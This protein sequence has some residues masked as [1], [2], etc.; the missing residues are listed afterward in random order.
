MNPIEIINLYKS[1]G[2]VTAVKGVSLEVKPGEIFG[3]IGPDGAGKTTI[4][5]TIVSLLLPDK[6]EIYFQG[7]EVSKNMAFVR[8]NIGY[9]P[10]R[11]S[12]YPDLTVEENL[13]FFADLFTVPR[14]EQQRI[15]MKLYEFS[16]LGPFKNRRAG[17]LSGGMK[18]KLA[19]S[20]MLVHEPA[21]IILDEP[22]F[23]VDPVSRSE[24][25]DI[26]KELARNGTSILVT[27]A[28]MDEAGL[29][30]RIGLIFEGKILAINTPAQLLESYGKQIYVVE[31]DQAHNVFEKLR[32]GGSCGSCN[33]FGDGVHIT[34]DHDITAESIRQEL[35]KL[36]LNYRSVRPIDPTLEDLFLELMIQK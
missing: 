6:G 26:L 17:A 29:C 31:T 15:K 21:V 13:N 8:S 25:W 24:F 5:R 32:A 4:I 11:F 10:Q 12:L 14:S 2:V 30:N 34:G 20:C 27:T 7:K 16:R 22:T 19:L 9:M 33:L 3:L 28:Y 23:G 35:D 18:Q 1:Y 36:G